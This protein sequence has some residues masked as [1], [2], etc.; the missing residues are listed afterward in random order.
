MSASLHLTENEKTI[1]RALR[2]AK[3]GRF[4]Q[5]AVSPTKTFATRA[6]IKAGGGFPCAATPPCGKILRTLDRSRVHVTT[7]AELQLRGHIAK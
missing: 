6:E 7:N 5:V 4:E 1:I 2:R 3:A